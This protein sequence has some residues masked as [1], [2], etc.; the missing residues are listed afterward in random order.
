MA[1]YCYTRISMVCLS[2][3]LS[4]CHVRQPCE[5]GSAQATVMPF[6]GLDQ[7][8]PRNHVLDGGQCRTNLF[9]AERGDNKAMRPFSKFFD[10][11]LLLLPLILS[12]V[13]FFVIFCS[14]SFV[15]F[16]Y[17]CRHS[18]INVFICSEF[19]STCYERLPILVTERW[20][21]SWFRCT[22]SQPAGDVSYPPGGRLRLLSARPAVNFP[23]AEHHRPLA[24]THFTVQ[25]SVYR[26]LS[27]PVIGTCCWI[28][29]SK[30]ISVRRGHEFALTI[31]SARQLK[32]YLGGR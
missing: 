12:L 11:L 20:V 26:R 7:V 30:S 16:V 23:A 8:C 28:K 29:N 22:G 3:C 15:C 14:Y 13:T 24:G 21:R 27:R 10:Q 31:T 9:A 4:V 19:H 18:E 5:N 17:F 2:V 32:R 6:E 25:R 1:A